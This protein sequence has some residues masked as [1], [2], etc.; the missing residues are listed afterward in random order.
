[1]MINTK[2]GEMDESLLEKREGGSDSVG[3]TCTWIEYWLKG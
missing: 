3:E 2:Y 1:M